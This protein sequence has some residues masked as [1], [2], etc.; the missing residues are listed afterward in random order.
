MEKKGLIKVEM[1]PD[2]RERVISLTPKGREILS[3]AIPLWRKAQELIST[4]LGG[5]RLSRLVDELKSV[6]ESLAKG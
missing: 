3:T 5:H 1:G 4:I 2:R 6:S